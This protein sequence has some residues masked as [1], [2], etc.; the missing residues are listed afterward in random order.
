[1][2]RRGDAG[3][4][5]GAAVSER[6]G[7]E[8]IRAGAMNPQAGGAAGYEQMLMA[9]FEQANRDEQ[10]LQ[11]Q[12]RAAQMQG[13]LDRSGIYNVGRF[14]IP[15]DLGELALGA[16][17]GPG[18]GKGMR[19]AL[20]ALGGLTTAPAEAEGA[21]LPRYMF[22]HLRGHPAAA[23]R[24]EADRGMTALDEV[25][26][27]SGHSD[28]WFATRGPDELNAAFPDML[29]AGAPFGA[30]PS[31]GGWR[32]LLDPVRPTRVMPRMGELADDALNFGQELTSPQSRV[33]F[34]PWYDS[35]VQGGSDP[36]VRMMPDWRPGA[37]SYSHQDDNI[38]IAATTQPSYMR[39]VLDHELQHRVQR[40]D[41]NRSLVGASV[42]YTSQ[43]NPDL[44][45]E[46]LQRYSQ[47][48]PAPSW[49]H[50]G[51]TPEPEQAARQ[52][53]YMNNFGEW[54]ARLAEDIQRQSRNAAQSVP[55]MNPFNTGFVSQIIRDSAME[56]M[57]DFRIR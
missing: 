3:E 20:A 48:E 35:A 40:N 15:Q 32:A 49:T 4:A 55:G 9:Q 27:A 19:T 52:A 12:A 45:D 8:G 17:M 16:A 7:L 14:M 43:R 54:E 18:L 31:E 57:P 26:R 41:P 22:Q 33:Y 10:E 56:P 51:T 11:R 46:Y 24:R 42:R 25:A 39:N 1:M 38:R 13:A 23:A 28:T 53:M 36:L 37:G 44:W 30:I 2:G 34:D 21:F 50:T 47:P 6:L 29:E 5:E